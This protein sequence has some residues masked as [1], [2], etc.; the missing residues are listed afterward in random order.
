VLQG[1]AAALPAP[2]AL[3]AAAQGTSQSPEVP[4][5]RFK[6]PLPPPP[7]NWQYQYYPMHPYYAADQCPWDWN[8]TQDGTSEDESHVFSDSDDDSGSLPP[9]PFPVKL[10]TGYVPPPAP[11]LPLDGLSDS[12]SDQDDII[13]VPVLPVP[14]PD[15]GAIAAPAVVAPTGIQLLQGHQ[16]LLQDAPSGPPLQSAELSKLADQMWMNGLRNVK[17]IYKK[18]LKPSNIDSVTAVNCNEELTEVLPKPPK[19]RDMKMRSVQHSLAAGAYPLLDI[20]DRCLQS[21]NIDKVAVCTLGLDSL[22]LLSQAHRTINYIRRASLKRFINPRFHGMCGKVTTTTGNLLFGSELVKQ[23][24]DRNEAVA[25]GRKVSPLGDRRSVMDRS[26]KRSNFKQQ[27]WV[28]RG[29][30]NHRSGGKYFA[31]L[32][33]SHSNSS[34]FSE[35]ISQ[36]DLFHIPHN[37]ECVSFDRTVLQEEVQ[38]TTGSECQSKLSPVVLPCANE[39][40]S[41]VS[42]VTSMV[43]I[44][45]PEFLAFWDNLSCKHFIA[46]NLANYIPAWK[47]ITSDRQVLQIIKG[48]QIKFDEF[49]SQSIHKHPL[50]LSSIDQG[51]ISKEL[52]TLLDKGVIELS[53]HEQDE[54]LSHV[55]T[56]QKKDSHKNRV[57]LNLSQLNENVE[58]LHFKMD[59]LSSALQLITPDCYCSSID[60]SD[61]YFTVNVDHEFRKFLKFVFDDQLYQFTALPNGL[62]PGPRYF[63]KILKPVL[64][65]IRQTNNILILSYL[66][67][68]LLIGDNSRQVASAVEQTVYLLDRLGFFINQDKSVLLPSTAIEFLG[69]QIDSHDMLVTMLPKKSDR[70]VKLCQDLLQCSSPSIRHVAQTLGSLSAT[71]PG[72][73]FAKLF[74]KYLERDKTRALNQSHGNYDA[75][76]HIS[77]K[78]KQDLSW[79]I[80]HIHTASVDLQIPDPAHILSTDASH[81]GWGAF[82]FNDQTSTGGRWSVSE[83]LLHINDLELLAVYYSLDSLLK[84][85][86]NSHIRIKTDNTTTK[87]CIN[88]QGSTQSQSCNRVARL[89]WDW[90]I[91]RHNWISASYL[92]GIQNYLADEASRKFSDETEWKLDSTMFAF[93]IDKFGSPDIDLFATRLNCQLRPFCSWR[94]DPE[95]TYVDAF[96]FVWNFNMVYIFPPFSLIPAILN[97]LRRDQTDAILVVP[98]WITQPWFSPLFK[99]LIDRPI[100]LPTTSTSLTLVHQPQVIHPLAGR[101]RLLACR[102]STNLVSR[103]AFQE[104]WCRPCR[105]P[106]ETVH[107]NNTQL[108]YRGGKFIV[109]N[110]Q[111]ICINLNYCRR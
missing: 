77:D 60:L 104:K 76:M 53:V 78:A 58:Y 68:L 95:A 83:N 57:I 15:G 30:R 23:A 43:R 96:S 12:D 34:Q 24:K 63:T 102:C 110:G 40:V 85:V 39:L 18:Y 111:S 20:V 8:P 109:V 99:M 17:D 49:P 106:A 70:I 101:L 32:N 35:F 10:P 6:R 62:S 74:T 108:T 7:M 61:A 80:S 92:P 59:T 37:I 22:T 3:P 88:H 84:N 93:I 46:G 55:F 87:I 56:R 2:P 25:L 98:L 86:Y 64:A 11:Q 48:L 73:R 28:N 14:P 38:E 9:A 107:I 36:K 13:P 66:D 90:C 33:Q 91:S 19:S 79:W 51:I 41:G 67:D 69:F 45:T 4:S 47:C 82:Y 26:H 103:K 5:K 29:G 94:P 71:A 16:Q 65:H 50:K 97:K 31:A 81:E 21:G 42:P 1:A 54:F 27:H 100:L 105:L 52:N 89:I 44:F 75:H 72:N